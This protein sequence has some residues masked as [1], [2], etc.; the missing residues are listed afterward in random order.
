MQE[1]LNPGT[2]LWNMFSVIHSTV[3][4]PFNF[5]VYNASHRLEENEVVDPRSKVT[6]KFP[7]DGSYFI[8]F[9]GRLV[10]CGGSSIQTENNNVLKSARLFSYLIVPDHN[11]NFT[12][13]VRS[14]PRLLKYKNVL[15]EGTVD[16]TSF[17]MMSTQWN[18]DE[19]NISWC[20]T[21]E[22]PSNKTII[23]N[24]ATVNTKNKPI[25]PVVGNMNEDGWEVY[26]GVDFLNKYPLFH[27]QLDKLNS[28]KSKHWKGI[29]STKRKLYV[30]SDI[31]NVTNGVMN[32][33]RDLY[34]PFTD[35]LKLLRK[36]PY[37]DEVNMDNKAILSNFGYV[38]EQ[39]P[40]RDYHSI[41]KVT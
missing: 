19:E 36:V 39:D 3:K 40:H 21:I 34:Q 24:N 8:V 16:T 1:Q 11:A 26:E 38:P 20:N 25:S 14:T 32:K 10:H 13:N 17:S 29:S 31:E 35:L 5:N 23:E 37:L 2:S 22:L 15:K 18:D 30:L 6:I 41:K 9:H 27:K 28:S 33:Y 12:G 4:E 7:Q